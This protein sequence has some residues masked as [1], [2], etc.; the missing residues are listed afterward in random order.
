MAIEEQVLGTKYGLKPVHSA[1]EI[2][3]LASRFPDNIKLF[4]AHRSGVMLGGVIMYETSC[5]AHAQYISATDEGKQLGALDRVLDFLINEY[6]TDK[7]YF[8]FGISTE[9]S[10]QYLN[11]GLIENKESFGARAVVYDFYELDLSTPRE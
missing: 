7:R 9:N 10:G 3:L 6:Y 5:V 1:A 11:L 8:D 4:A 2:E